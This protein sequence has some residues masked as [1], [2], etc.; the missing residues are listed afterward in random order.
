MNQYTAFKAKTR[1]YW[2]KIQKIDY[3]Y[4]GPN[5]NDDVKLKARQIWE[6]SQNGRVWPK[7]RFI[8]VGSFSG[9]M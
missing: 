2:I 6:T 3:M 5:K 1:K 9:Y 8:Y 7:F 4:S